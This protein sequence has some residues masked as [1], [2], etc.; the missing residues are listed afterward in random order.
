MVIAVRNAISSLKQ[1]H[2]PFFFIIG[3][4]EVGGYWC[5]ITLSTIPG[6]PN[7][8]G[9]RDRFCGRQFFHTGRAMGEDGFRM[10]QVHYIYCVLYYYISSSLD[11]L[12]LDCRCH[13]QG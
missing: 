12:A 9:T 8:F 7:L 2:L 1:Y 10:I 3:I 13:D 5:K 4:P 11:H 6:V